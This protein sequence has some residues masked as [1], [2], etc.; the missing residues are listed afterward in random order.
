MQS[1]DASPCQMTP[2]PGSSPA[3]LH[4]V[5]VI[6]TDYDDLDHCYV[7]SLT[8]LA[9]TDVVAAA[10]SNHKLKLYSLDDS[11]L[12]FSGELVGHRGIIYDVTVTDALPNS[13]FTVCQDGMVREWDARSGQAVQMYFGG[14]GELYS[15]STNGHLLA[16]GSQDKILFW[17]RRSKRCKATFSDTH[18][19][20]VTQVAFHSEV[21][22]AFVSGS[23]DGLIASF[24]VSRE[25]SEDEGFKAGLNIGTSVSLLG[26]YGANN[27]NLWCCSGTETLH[28]WHWRDACN[29]ES[30]VDYDSLRESNDVR[31][32]LHLSDGR[33]ADYLIR[34]HDGD[35]DGLLLF[36]GSNG[37]AAGL[38]CVAQ[39]PDGRNLGFRVRAICGGV[40]GHQDVVRSSLRFDRSC[41]VTGGEDSRI[42]IWK[43]GL[44]SGEVPSKKGCVGGFVT[45]R[46]PAHISRSIPY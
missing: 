46:E 35:S 12:R 26:F 31:D 21:K 4:P 18:A 27:E 15:C 16:S 28:L 32:R 3:V 23:V 38:F 19:Q 33:R 2:V 14:G 36:A 11:A 5:G 24:D 9:L 45:R 7:L 37:G 20:D 44:S 6:N 8:K 42:C 41:W 39:E 43:A 17:D 30:S 22:N 13:I 29:E 10:L 40:N 1:S 25:L 34:C